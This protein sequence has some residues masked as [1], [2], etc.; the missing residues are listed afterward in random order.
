MILPVLTVCSNALYAQYQVHVLLNGN[1][2][3]KMDVHEK[4]MDDLG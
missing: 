1:A 2:N 4:G 3:K